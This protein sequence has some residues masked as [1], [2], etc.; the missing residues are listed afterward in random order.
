MRYSWPG[1]VRELQNMIQQAI[2][3]AQPPY[4]ELDDMPHLQEKV[5]RQPRRTRLTDLPLREAK[6]DF[7]K[8]Y[9]VEILERQGYNVS[10]SARE[11]GID[12]KNFYQ[13]IKKYGIQMRTT[14]PDSAAAQTADGAE[15]DGSKQPTLYAIR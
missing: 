3:Y 8:R 6:D 12:R 4:V 5:S 7:E 9:C 1:N 11:A 15:P 13:K 14:K 10:A 2:I